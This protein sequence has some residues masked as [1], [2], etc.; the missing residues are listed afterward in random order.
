[1]ANID[2]S[3]EGVQALS[4]L[5]D[6]ITSTAHTHS[7]ALD[8]V[9]KLKSL[10]TWKQIVQYF[11]TSDKVEMVQNALEAVDACVAS[12]QQAVS[13]NIL[14]QHPPNVHVRPPDV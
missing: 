7:S 8:A 3:P 6:V 4:K 5:Q 12:S 14:H 13:I 1:M 2:P 11:Q 9:A 10:P